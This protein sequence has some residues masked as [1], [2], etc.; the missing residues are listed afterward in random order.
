MAAPGSRARRRRVRH[1]RAGAG[2][3]TGEAPGSAR[4]D[5]GLPRRPDG[6]RR[7]RWRHAHVLPPHRRRAGVRA[8][9]RPGRGARRRPPR[10]RPPPRRP[11]G[12]G[13][14]ARAPGPAPGDRHLPPAPAARLPDAT[15]LDRRARVAARS[16]HA[17]PRPHR[18][19]RRRRPAGHRARDPLPP[20]RGRRRAPP[21]ADRRR[22]GPPRPRRGPD[23]ARGRHPPRRGPRRGPHDLHPRLRRRHRAPRHEHP[24]PLRR[25]AR[26]G[27]AA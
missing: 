12:R 18:L 9:R 26:A 7:R 19:V 23:P 11:A 22:R 2:R 27:L 15:V 13:R 4:A 3:R 6:R 10:H 20:G 5:A 21:G 1:R 16:A 25:R 17:D 8:L 14:L 24:P